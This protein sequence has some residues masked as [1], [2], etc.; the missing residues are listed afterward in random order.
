MNCQESGTAAGSQLSLYQNSHA[1]STEHWTSCKGKCGLSFIHESNNPEEKQDQFMCVCVCVCVC[2]YM[3][4][5]FSRVWF[6]NPV[7]CSPP[8]SS[9]HGILQTKILEWVAMPSSRGS[10]WS[11]D[12]TH[13]SYVYLH[14]QVDS[15]PLSHWGSPHQLI[16]T[17]K[18]IIICE[19]LR[20][21]P[22]IE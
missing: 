12:L 1:Q 21:V 9:V 8:G 13:I 3:L 2:V 20:T 5:W 6:C 7:D 11:G 15:L 22:A 17:I 10:S 19:I 16:T 18:W 4:S 14:W